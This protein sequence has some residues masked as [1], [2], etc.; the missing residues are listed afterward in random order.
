MADKTQRSKKGHKPN[1]AARRKRAIYKAE[2]RYAKNKRRKAHKEEV[3]KAKLERK[4]ERR[5]TQASKVDA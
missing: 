5:K 3:K 1:E 4:R 2:N